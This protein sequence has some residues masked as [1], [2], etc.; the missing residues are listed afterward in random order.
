[1]RVDATGYHLAVDDIEEIFFER[2]AATRVKV[3]S[4]KPR[5]SN[6]PSVQIVDLE[7]Q[8]IRRLLR[9]HMRADVNPKNLE[10]SSALGNHRRAFPHFR[11][12]SSLYTGRAGSVVK[13][14]DRCLHTWG[15]GSPKAAPCRQGM[16]IHQGGRKIMGKYS[17]QGIP[18]S[19]GIAP[20]QPW[21]SRLLHIQVREYCSAI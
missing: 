4:A 8:V 9:Q 20:P 3:W 5:K 2:K 15:P 6:A 11:E 18:Q 7:F 10:I 17:K 1:M 19:L 14:R 12:F 21:P 13:K 16:T